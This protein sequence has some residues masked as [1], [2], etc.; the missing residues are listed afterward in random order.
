MALI[1]PGTGIGQASGKLGAL[2]FSH[3]RGGAY[4]RARSMPTQPGGKYQD[5]IRACVEAAS[6]GWRTR[7]D[8]ERAAWVTWA[9]GHPMPNRVGQSIRLQGNAA[10]VQ[11]NARRILWGD[12]QLFVPP[13]V[14]PPGRAGST[15]LL[16]R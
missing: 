13:A 3:N 7:T 9:D 11:I 5:G 2:V 4:V 14:D 8:A 10:Y 15:W 12:A 6:K 1:V 16:R